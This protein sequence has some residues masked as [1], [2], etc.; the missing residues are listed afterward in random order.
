[1]PESLQFKVIETAELLAKH[2]DQGHISGGF[3]AQWRQDFLQHLHN[4]V[5]LW[6]EHCCDFAA[7]Y[8]LY[9]TLKLSI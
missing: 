9:P 6:T 3:A 2:F 5:H 7:L 8:T 4:F 1:M